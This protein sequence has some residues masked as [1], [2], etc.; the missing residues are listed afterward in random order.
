MGI[1]CCILLA[2]FNF[3]DTDKIGGEEGDTGPETTVD[4]I[5]LRIQPELNLMHF[6][7]RFHF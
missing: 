5:I 4:L 1:F 3:H 7:F 2:L 6:H